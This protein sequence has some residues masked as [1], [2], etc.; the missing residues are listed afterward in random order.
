MLLYCRRRFGRRWKCRRVVSTLVAS[1][2]AFEA[3]LTTLYRAGRCCCCRARFEPVHITALRRDGI[4][5]AHDV[6]G[7]VPQSSL[8]SV[9]PLSL[10][11]MFVAQFAMGPCAATTGGLRQRR[12]WQSSR[13]PRR[14]GGRRVGTDDDSRAEQPVGGGDRSITDGDGDTEQRAGEEVRGWLPIPKNDAHVA[15]SPLGPSPILR[16][17]IIRLPARER[18]G[19]RALANKFTMVSAVMCCS[20]HDKNASIPLMTMPHRTDEEPVRQTFY[21][22]KSVAPPLPCPHEVLPRPS[23]RLGRPPRGSR[24]GRAPRH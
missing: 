8:G 3:Q 17:P 23:S 21:T 1:P 12:W 11:P 10:P 5:A 24:C 9:G 18:P 13:Q 15:D 4:A 6:G 16:L 2:N 7:G 14:C 19:R 20:I 22:A